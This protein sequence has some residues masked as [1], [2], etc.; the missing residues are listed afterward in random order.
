MT[1]RKWCAVFALVAVVASASETEEAIRW[2]GPYRGFNT[3]SWLSE[4]DLRDLAATG[5]NVVRIGFATEPML[6]MSA[7]YG[8][9]ESALAHLDYLL[10][11][12]EESGLRVVI[13]PHTAP[14]FTS[15]WAPWTTVPQDPFWN[16]ALPY[17]DAYV[18][19]WS[20]IAQRYKDRGTVI[21][22]YDLLNEPG[23]YG[24]PG[25]PSAWDVLSKRLVEAIREHD[26]R[27]TIVIE[28]PMVY[29]PDK[30]VM[31]GIDIDALFR[32][33]F[34]SAPPDDNVVYS[35]HFYSPTK[36][37]F[38]GVSGTPLPDPPVRY[39]GVVDGG[40]YDRA[41]FEE[42]MR[43]AAIFQHRFGVPIFVGEFGNARWLGDDGNR[44]LSDAIRVFEKY[45]WSWANH[46][47][48]ECEC[49]DAERSNTD[50]SDTKVYGDTP[51]MQILRDAFAK[52]A[53][54]ERPVMWWMANAASYAEGTVAPGEM[55]EIGGAG[56]GPRDGLGL[57]WTQEGRVAKELGGV[58]VTFEGMVAPVTYASAG[59]VRV[60]VPYG[61][62][63]KE[64]VRMAVRYRE[65]VSD[66]M[67]L[68]VT[69]TAPG[70][71][72]A[73][74]SGSGPG[75]I[76][77]EDG[78]MNSAVRAAAVGS[79][80]TLFATGEGETDP[81]GVDGQ[82]TPEDAQPKPLSEVKVMVGGVEAEVV[83]AGGARGMYAGV[84]EIQVRVPAVEPGP[85]V[86]VTV[87]MGGVE[88]RAV[89]LAVASTSSG[90]SA[91]P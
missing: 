68:W 51:R 3:H 12:C 20:T 46:A 84:L 2:K 45:N 4:K 30:R 81:A 83:S 24:T 11:V 47:W 65:G 85:E 61:V 64:K 62:A 79:V 15:P 43:G 76:L 31:E 7:P 66:E 59:R 77:N 27:H 75:L 6:E 88:S 25:E 16:P 33:G 87:T 1:I 82:P 73:D 34:L 80:V 14:G 37:A 40:R 54:A 42:L 53:G 36:F 86:P 56:L 60:V 55:V 29:L 28:P 50:K 35:P 67:E 69:A 21:A 38:Q 32:A 41:K 72:S 90:S 63:G 17:Q 19:L 39:P 9:K 26:K 23:V 52:K 49:W 78:R 10:N 70:L 74:G 71:F 44:W 57:M 13:D 48:R 5:A 8:V 89:G 18:K 22:G 91:R 58:Q